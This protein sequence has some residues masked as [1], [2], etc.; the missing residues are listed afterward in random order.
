MNELQYLIGGQFLVATL[1]VLAR[2]R[3]C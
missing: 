3:A 2:D 1:M